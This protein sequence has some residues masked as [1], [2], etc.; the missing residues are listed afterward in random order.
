MAWLTLSFN[1]SHL[2]RSHSFTPFSYSTT[3]LHTQILRRHSRNPDVQTSDITT[4]RHNNA[5]SK[6]PNL[7]A[8]A[9]QTANRAHILKEH[10]KLG[11]M[12]GTGGGIQSHRLGMS[13]GT[14]DSP[15]QGGNRNFNRWDP[16]CARVPETPADVNEAIKKAVEAFYA[17]SCEKERKRAWWAGI[18]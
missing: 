10:E 4:Q 3:S 2:Q 6:S 17:E 7:S 1:T 13:T 5:A 8:Q 11:G 16:P 14:L 12:G 18:K 15:K 9:I